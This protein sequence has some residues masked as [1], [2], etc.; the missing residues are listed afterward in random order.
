MAKRT[1]LYVVLSLC[2]ATMA[3]LLYRQQYSMVSKSAGTFANDTSEGKFVPE[4]E[5]DFIFVTTNSEY[6]LNL[7]VVV[8]LILFLAILFLIVKK[9]IKF[10]KS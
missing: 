8:I 5:T 1:S 10:K 7:P 4:K 6:S 2:I 3:Y 9:M